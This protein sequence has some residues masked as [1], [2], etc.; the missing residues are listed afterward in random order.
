MKRDRLA[1]LANGG[2]TAVRSIGL[3]GQPIEHARRLGAVA[4]HGLGF[5]GHPCIR[6]IPCIPSGCTGCKGCKAIKGVVGGAAEPPH[7]RPNP[8]LKAPTAEPV[9]RLGAEAPIA[10]GGAVGWGSWGLLRMGAPTPTQS[11]P[12]P[13]PCPQGPCIACNATPGGDCETG[14]AKAPTAAHL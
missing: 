14:E 2:L 11:L 10:E 12:T 7:A 3:A 4:L 8:A 1:T 13:L 6:C 9:Q 5:V